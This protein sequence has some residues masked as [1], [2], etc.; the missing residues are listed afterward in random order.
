ME[1]E[2]EEEDSRIQ[3]ALICNKGETHQ[4]ENYRHISSL[5]ALYKPFA[6]KLQIRIAD[7]PNS[8]L[9][10]NSGWIQ[11]K[12]EHGSCNTHN[13]NRNWILRKQKEPTTPVS[14]DLEKHFSK[15]PEKGSSQPWKNGRRTKADRTIKAAIQKHYPRR[16]KH[17]DTVESGKRNA[18]E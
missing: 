5:N 16:R 8:R 1:E 6:A 13:K 15:W 7:T 2:I 10:K 18:S 12:R 9:R 4:F 3:V 14:L 11:K 17:M